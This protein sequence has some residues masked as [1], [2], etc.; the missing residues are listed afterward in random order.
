[1]N[2]LEVLMKKILTACMVLAAAAGS[3]FADWDKTIS[4]GMSFPVFNQKY[5][6]EDSE[7]DDDAKVSGIG[8]NFDVQ[9]RFVNN[10]NNLALL[11]GYSVGYLGVDADNILDDASGTF[12]G[13]NQSIIGGI[14]Y[15][16]V[17]TE[18]FQ[19]TASALAGMTFVNLS[20]DLS[21]SD[22]D[23]E[24][25]IPFS[26]KADVDYSAFD[27]ELGADIFAQFYFTEHWGISASCTA[28]FTV[29][30]SGEMEIDIKRV[31]IPGVG[32]YTPGALGMSGKVSDDID[33]KPGSFIFV[34]RIMAT[35]RF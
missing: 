32:S 21:Y 18:R 2:Y 1:M 12:S 6:I 27:F 31:S 17:N 16:F 34:P 22:V 15:R 3:V 4:F 7:D 26:M 29:A 20:T 35:Y 10:N 28:L 13:I 8:V 14:G 9:G 11:A 23:E 33:V 30:G 24:D 5:E 25:G 19:L